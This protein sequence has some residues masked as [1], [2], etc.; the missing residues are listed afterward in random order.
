MSLRWMV[1]V[2]MGCVAV[3]ATLDSNKMMNQLVKA[4][5]DHK[6]CAA[7]S[8]DITIMTVRYL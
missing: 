3:L 5:D 8:D 4:L 6:E 2:A 7:Q 1:V